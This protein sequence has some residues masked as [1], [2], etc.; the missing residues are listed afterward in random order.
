MYVLAAVLVSAT[1]ALGPVPPPD[2]DERR[3]A[4][5]PL[6][7]DGELPGDWQETIGDRLL[8]GMTRAGLSIVPPSQHGVLS[9]ANASCVTGLGQ[10]AGA[11][12]VVE[13]RLRV[14]AERRNYTLTVRVLSTTSG[15][16]VATIGGTCDL[17]GFEEGADLVEAKAGAVSDLLQKLQLGRPSVRISSTPAGATLQIDGHEAGTTPLSVELDPGPHRV[18]A[19]MP[20]FLAQTFEVEAVEGVNK[21]LEFRLLEEPRRPNNPPTAPARGRGL[22]IAGAVLVGAGLAAIVAGGVLLAID[23]RPYR[24]R[25]DADAD[26]DC[27]FMYGTQTAGIVTLSLGGAALI[28]GAGLLIGGKMAARQS[29]L[30]LFPTG[31]TLRF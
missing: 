21:E 24:R 25:C 14:E 2:A 27:R 18:R 31:A 19:T 10:S 8:T 20:G 3:V 29:R 4:V 7:I 1:V 30:S 23:G 17:C 6:D 13:A 12:Y 11:D 15:Q 22:V 26:G 28:G 16:E 9:C 5:L